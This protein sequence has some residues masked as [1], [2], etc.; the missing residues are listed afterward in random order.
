VVLAVVAVMAVAVAVAPEA[1]R[2]AFSGN[3]VPA[4]CNIPGTM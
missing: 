2:H 3:A 1:V 4:W